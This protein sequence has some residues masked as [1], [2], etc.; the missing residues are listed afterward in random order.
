MRGSTKGRGRARPSK[1]GPASA[2]DAMPV[3]GTPWVA[4]ALVAG[5]A[6]A[7]FART[8]VAGFVW[9]DHIIVEANRA[10]VN[11][12][13]LPAAFGAHAFAGAGDVMAGEHAVEYYRP[14]WIV[15]LGLQH[16]ASGLRP[17]GY[18]LTGILLHVLAS[19]AVLLLG[20]AT[21]R[22][23]TATL[24]AGLLFAVHPVHVEA[25][26]WVSASNE[27]LA[28]LFGILF[29]LAYVRLR[30]SGGGVTAAGCVLALL[31]ALFSKETAVALPLLALLWELR[32]GG[33]ALVRRLR[34][35]IGLGLVALGFVVLRSQMVQP[36]PETHPL[37]WRVLTAPRLLAEYLGLLVFPFRLRVFHL[38]PFVKHAMDVALVV[39]VLVIAAWLALAL[40]ARNRSPMLFVGLVWV[41][42]ALLPVC[43][44]LVAPQPALLAERYLY[45]PSVGAVLAA[46]A[47]YS[48][49]VN[50]AAARRRFALA[51][52]ALIVLASFTFVSVRQSRVWRDDLS[53]MSRMIL[54]AP[55]SAMGHANLG[56]A[57]ERLGRLE[58]ASREYRAA[59]VLEPGDHMMHRN[60]AIALAKR[61]LDAEAEKELRI[62]L[63]LKPDY[64]QARGDL[65]WL[66]ARQARWEEAQREYAAALEQRPGDVANRSGLAEAHYDL[67]VA[68]SRQN[69][70]EEAAKEFEAAIALQ[71]R[72]AKA[73]FNLGV[74]RVRQG[75][76]AQAV[77]EF[78]RAIEFAPPDTA[79]AGR[80]VAARRIAAAS[81]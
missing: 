68:L 81:K 77:A 3:A 19:V 50:S 33:E 5:L 30:R 63:S 58:D 25:V 76:G 74:M 7:V 72:W 26:A 10:I 37:A 64:V 14:I 67:G 11:L 69:R 6:A 20:R 42:M 21:L 79:L 70:T 15:A 32:P 53:L 49:L 55:A 45:L 44:I 62:A 40:W 75:R 31:C 71:P 38:I 16:A 36:H 24:F 8:L 57:L 27:L 80:A 56:A 1:P 23:P 43:G 51:A 39:P 12:A 22:D 60:L 61:D 35:P 4:I 78:D 54:D 29:M 73:R 65:G 34:W 13:Q 28:G 59:I 46:G 18:H 48:V 2:L 9:D 41:P 47:I 66:F 52:V 17:L